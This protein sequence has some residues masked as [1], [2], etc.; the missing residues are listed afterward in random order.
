MLGMENSHEL[1][2]RFRFWVKKSVRV[3]CRLWIEI[4]QEALASWAF[5]E[6]DPCQ[7]ANLEA[8]RGKKLACQEW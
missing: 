8:W 2:T 5:V 4:E 1:D 7:W 3:D 6:T